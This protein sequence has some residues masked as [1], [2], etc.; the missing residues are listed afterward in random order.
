MVLQCLQRLSAAPEC[1]DTLL[2]LPNIASRL[3]A[4]YT[5][6]NEA[7]AAEVAKLLLR[8]WSPHTSRRGTGV[9]LYVRACLSGMQT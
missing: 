9:S 5:C 6:G 2:A 4:V 7:I 1:M 8:W 3:W